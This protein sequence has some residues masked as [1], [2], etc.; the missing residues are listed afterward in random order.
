MNQS[1]RVGWVYPAFGH[2]AHDEDDAAYGHPAHRG[3][4]DAIGADPLLFSPVSVGPL[5]GTLVEDAVAAVRSSFPE[6]DVY[7]L[8]NADA[9]YAAPV[10]KSA[11]PD[12]VVVLLAA[13]N[14]FGLESYDFAADPLPKALA[15]RAD[16][17]LDA[18]VVRALVRRYVDG[19]LAVSSFVAD[20]VRSF[21]PETP[22]RPVHPYVQPDVADRLDEATP[23]LGANRAITV[24]EA[25]D[26]K[27]VDLLVEAWPAV[28]GRVPDATLH[29]VGTGH[30]DEYESTP[31]VT[32]H[33]YVE[34][35]TAELA[36]S[37]LYVHP[38]RVDAFGVSVTEAMRAG[39][40][41]LVTETT[42]SFPVVGDIAD[43]LVVEP[44]PAALAAGISGYFEREVVA[45]ER[46]SARARDLAA[47]FDAETQQDE[48]V[49]AF[50]ELL[51]AIDG[52]SDR[53][54]ARDGGGSA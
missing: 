44:N 22:V 35:L 8:E 48:F 4:Q 1:P 15:R 2:P 53:N 39:V 23:D 36:A 24:C 52:A 3:F 6:R 50:E 9:V 31:G 27:G 46:L 21:A 13:H 26:H 40:V 38:A 25:R 51:A 29:V 37:S 41:P 30:P 47:P 5:S 32:V 43:D 11:H 20:H 10:I 14:V 16:R 7:V 33:G 18:T 45:R 17:Y 54:G 28:R 12:A 19:S 34:D 49:A 42:G